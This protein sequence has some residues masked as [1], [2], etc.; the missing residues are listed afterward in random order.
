MVSL[1]LDRY[2]ERPR[3]YAE[4]NELSWAQGFLGEW[5]QIPLPDTYGVS[6]IPAVFLIGPDGKVIA[7][8][9]RGEAI[10]S[11]VEKALGSE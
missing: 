2:V 9:L 5:T 7:R 1:S 3:E 4:E 11:A 8:N 10:E 6:G